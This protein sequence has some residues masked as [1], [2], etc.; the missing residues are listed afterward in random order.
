MTYGFKQM[1]SFPRNLM[2]EGARLIQDQQHPG[3]Q[4]FHW[5]EGRKGKGAE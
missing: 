1:V 3:I 5:P 4:F 2:I